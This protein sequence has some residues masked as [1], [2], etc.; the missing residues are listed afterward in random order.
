VSE[1]NEPSSHSE[2]GA[3]LNSDDTK[4]WDKTEGNRGAAVGKPG[5]SKEKGFQLISSC[6]DDLQMINCFRIA[7]ML[8]GG[9]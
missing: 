6:K 7:L 9:A 2:L 5:L 8:A 4:R 1:K 3:L